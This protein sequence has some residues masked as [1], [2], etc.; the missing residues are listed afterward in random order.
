MMAFWLLAATLVAGAMACLLPPLLRSGRQG[1]AEP[2]PRAPIDLYREQLDDIE[3]D[4]NVGT[5]DATLG[6]EARNEVGRR[7]LE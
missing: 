6:R 5:L 4:L 7:L 1:R 3:A 2:N